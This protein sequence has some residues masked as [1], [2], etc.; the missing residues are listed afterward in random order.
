MQTDQP[1]IETALRS[2]E[3]RY[4]RQELVRARSCGTPLLRVIHRLDDAP[5]RFGHF[6]S[7]PPDILDFDPVGGAG[8]AH[9][10]DANVQ[11]FRVLLIRFGA[12]HSGHNGVALRETPSIERTKDALLHSAK[13]D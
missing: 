11:N 8:F 9:V 6:I 7:P 10:T 3:S 12:V 5:G 4:H 2:R 1:A 13:L